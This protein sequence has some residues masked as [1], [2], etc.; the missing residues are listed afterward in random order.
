M[1]V[2]KYE[3]I[4]TKTRPFTEH[5]VLLSQPNDKHPTYV[6][7]YSRFRLYLPFTGSIHSK[8]T[9]RPHNVQPI[10]PRC[11]AH[12]SFESPRCRQPSRPLLPYS[13]PHQAMATQHSHSTPSVR[14][15]PPNVRAFCR[16]QPATALAHSFLVDWHRGLHH[17]RLTLALPPPPRLHGRRWRQRLRCEASRLVGVSHHSYWRLLLRSGQ[18][19]D[20]RASPEHTLRHSGLQQFVLFY[21]TRR[22]E[23]R[24]GSKNRRWGAR[25][26]VRK[27]GEDR[28]SHVQVIQFL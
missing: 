12:P 2:I 11:L 25:V 1:T 22:E 14:P 17:R 9:L 7:H 13:L 24:R 23:T 8:H 26:G 20:C 4:H 15:P 16:R 27:Y 3:V 10:S 21:D 28:M 18:G 6:T 19:P 5:R